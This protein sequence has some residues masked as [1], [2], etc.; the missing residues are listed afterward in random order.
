MFNHVAPYRYL[1]PNLYLSVA[2]IA[3]PDLFVCSSRTYI[4][5]YIARFYEEHY[6]PSSESAGPACQKTVIGHPV[7]GAGWVATICTGFARPLWQFHHVYAVSFGASGVPYSNASANGSLAKTNIEFKCPSCR[8]DQIPNNT[9]LVLDDMA[10]IYTLPTL[11]PPTFRELADC[12]L[13][14]IMSIGMVNKCTRDHF[15]VSD[16]EHQIS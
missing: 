13:R 1:L 2:D 6:Q 10:V 5:L 9:A 16:G 4:S 3:N 11:L 7:L 12:V 8:V 15:T 14:H